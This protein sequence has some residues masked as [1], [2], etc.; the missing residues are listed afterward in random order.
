MDLRSMFKAGDVV[1]YPDGRLDYLVEM[2]GETGLWVNACNPS[3]I[4]RGLRGF[5]EECY[6][7]FA[8]RLFEGTAVIGHF[9]EGTCDDARFWYAEN[10]GAYHG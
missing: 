6:P 8:E 9:G 4:E 3:W 7:F 1:R 10:K 2:P 5:C